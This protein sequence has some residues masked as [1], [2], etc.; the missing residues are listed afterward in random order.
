MRKNAR[1]PIIAETINNIA[2]TICINRSDKGMKDKS[3][4]MKNVVLVMI[5]LGLGLVG[6]RA[7]SPVFFGSDGG[8]GELVVPKLSAAAQAGKKAF[9]QSCASCHGQHAAGSEKG[10]PLIHDYYNPGHHG[11]G[12]F[13]V[14]VARG[15]RQHHWNFG[16]MPPQPNVSKNQ[17]RMIIQYVRELQI[18]NG[19]KYK[20][21]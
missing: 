2:I 18:A 8:M 3:G 21:H 7:L 5:G 15:V 16:H 6:W 13:Y 12:A 4:P 10:P 1:N 9:D 14:A 19:I 20:P 17:A 11:D